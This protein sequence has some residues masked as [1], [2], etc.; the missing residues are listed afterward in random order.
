MK[1]LPESLFNAGFLSPSQRTNYDFPLFMTA[2]MRT[3]AKWLEGNLKKAESINTEWNS[4]TLKSLYRDLTGQELTNGEFIAAMIVAGFQYS[5]SGVNGTFNVCGKSISEIEAKA[6]LSLTVKL[7]RGGAYLSSVSKF[8]EMALNSKGSFIKRFTGGK[9]AGK[10]FTYSYLS[11]KADNTLIRFLQ[12][13]T[14]KI[15]E[16][17]ASAINEP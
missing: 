8:N 12:D 6:Y 7:Q 11:F 2:K 4:Y 13:N 9:T 10:P 5:K 14:G 15:I 17:E 1:H 3:V 16:A